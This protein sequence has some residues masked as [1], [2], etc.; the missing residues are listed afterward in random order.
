MANTTYSFSR[1]ISLVDYQEPFITGSTLYS[2]DWKQ[3]VTEKKTNRLTE[4]VFSYA[5]LPLPRVT[6]EYQPIYYADMAE[7]GTT[8]FTSVKYSLATRFSYELLKYDWHIR[9]LMGKAGS[10]MG[11]SHAQAKD[12]VIAQVFNRLTSATLLPMH[13]ALAAATTHTMADGTTTVLNLLTAAS[14]SYDNLWSMINYFSTAMYDQAGRRI[15]A[16]PKFIVTHPQNEKSLEKILQT[17]WD[18]NWEPDNADRNPNIIKLRRNLKAIYCP[19]LTSTT[20]Y[21]LLADVFPED[22]W[23][24]NVEAPQF[25]QEDDFDIHGSKIKSWQIFSVGLKEFLNLC[26]NA[27]A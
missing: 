19:F 12:T 3:V 17:S 7:L 27:G 15:V 11:K 18:Q 20:Q 26:H 25:D 13:D 16:T 9:D 22:L 21:T 8:T 23:V 1:S 2:W 10:Q 4:Q 14:L 6:S 24:F 5:G